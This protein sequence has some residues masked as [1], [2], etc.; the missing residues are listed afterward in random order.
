MLQITL[1]FLPTSVFHQKIYGT[2]GK[3]NGYEDEGV[4]IFKKGFGG[5]VIEQPGNFRLVVNSMMD[6]LYNLSRIIRK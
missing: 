4:Y 5:R 1:A 2:N 3:F 6:K